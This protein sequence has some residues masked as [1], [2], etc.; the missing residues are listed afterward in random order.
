MCCDDGEGVEGWQEE[1]EEEEEEEKTRLEVVARNEKVGFFFFRGLVS[2]MYGHGIGQYSRS[3][4][5]GDDPRP[6]A[7]H[8]RKEEGQRGPKRAK[9]AQKGHLSRIRGVITGP[10][11]IRSVLYS[12][13][14][15]SQRPEGGSK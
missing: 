5:W 7:A 2:R 4:L 12:H 6:A 1:E 13:Y 14:T 9:W 15:F 10:V 11:P 3:G 8:A